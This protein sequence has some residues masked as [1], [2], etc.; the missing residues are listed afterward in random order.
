[1]A[2]PINYEALLIGFYLSK[3]SSVAYDKLGYKTMKATYE[4]ASL[5]V[6]ETPNNIKNMRDEFDPYYDNGR[7]GWYQNKKLSKTRQTVKDKYESYSEEELFELV[8]QLFQK[9]AN[10]PLFTSKD[11]KEIAPEDRAAIE[12]EVAERKMLVRKR[13]KASA[14]KCKDRDK[15]KCRACSFYYK[16]RVVECHHLVPLHISGKTKI[17]PEELITLCPTCHRLAHCLLEE[18]AYNQNVNILLSNLHKILQP[19]SS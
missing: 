9:A 1:M 3:F 13:N 10:K 11:K 7:V 4:A 19:A 15:Y 18:D 14:D 8:K 5:A 2:K 12:G 6:G 17:N 16:K